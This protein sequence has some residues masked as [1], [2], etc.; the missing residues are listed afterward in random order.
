MNN[1][2]FLLPVHMFLPVLIFSLVLL[3]KNSSSSFLSGVF[4]C[5]GFPSLKNISDGPPKLLYRLPT[6]GRFRGGD[7]SSAKQ[8]MIAQLRVR[9]RNGLTVRK[10]IDCFKTF[11]DLAKDL[12]LEHD[13]EESDVLQ[14]RDEENRF[15]SLFSN[16]SRIFDAN[17][18]DGDL[19][20]IRRVDTLN[21]EKSESSQPLK[22]FHTKSNA[23]EEYSKWKKVSIELGSIVQS[24]VVLPSERS[25]APPQQLI[26]QLLQSPKAFHVGL[27]LQKRSK[28]RHVSSKISKKKRET[29]NIE[30]AGIME[31]LHIEVDD[32]Q[33]LFRRISFS[34]LAKDVQSRK[35]IIDGLGLEIVGCSFAVGSSL[36]NSVD[37]ECILSAQVLVSTFVQQQV[38]QDFTE[39]SDL[40]Y[41]F[42]SRLF[43]TKL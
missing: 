13:I 37:S 42:I 8:G 7:H 20:V 21:H 4:L 38:L 40:K 24:A 41:F 14:I 5:R 35:V 15:Q 16:K 27:I 22:G 39:K 31:L 30:V 9:L 19:W 11:S 34:N 18:S 2:W 32:I 23:N 12:T 26:L 36:C 33:E 3:C 29:L 6:V 10:N 25:R 17:F 1:A 28:N 43:K